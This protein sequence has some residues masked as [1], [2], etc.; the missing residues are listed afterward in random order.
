MEIVRKFTGEL[1]AQMSSVSPTNSWT[2]DLQERFGF[3]KPPWFL[4]PLPNATGP[5]SNTSWSQPKS[6][7]FNK[8]L[9]EIMNV[10]QAVD[11]QKLTQNLTIG[12]YRSNWEATTEMAEMISEHNLC[13]RDD[14]VR[15]IS[16]TGRCGEQSDTRTN[17]GH[18]SDDL[19]NNSQVWTSKLDVLKLMVAQ[20]LNMTF[21]DFQSDHF[22]KFRCAFTDIATDLKCA[23]FECPNKH[24]LDIRSQTCYRPE[25]VNFQLFG[26]K[27]KTPETGD[28][29]GITQGESDGLNATSPPVSVCLCLKTHSVMTNLGWWQ[30][31]SDTSSLLEG[32]CELTILG[33]QTERD[34]AVNEE[35]DELPT[36]DAVTARADDLG[37]N[38]PDISSSASEYTVVEEDN[39][40]VSNY[41]SE[42][43]LNIWKKDAQRCSSEEHSLMARWCFS[44]WKSLKYY[45]TCFSWRKRT[46]NVEKNSTQSP[47][48]SYSS[49]ASSPFGVYCRSWYE[50]S[51]SI[52]AFHIIAVLIKIT[53]TLISEN[54]VW[55]YVFPQ[56]GGKS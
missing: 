52:Y 43:I 13:S 21:F 34:L 47:I 12:M 38:S 6:S 22:G 32:R 55:L 56:T 33:Y 1:S 24:L 9:I 49:S 48:S 42:L 10:H 4:K 14:I 37:E 17:P 7:L 36:E 50:Q 25:R 45:E 19:D 2:G 40:F 46:T 5:F 18:N 3:S 39:L 23:M 28:K 54:G 30:V 41:F 27:T 29:T 16:C 8:K 15:R 20:S 51:R 44:G 31:I 53:H 26:Q 11:D 35:K